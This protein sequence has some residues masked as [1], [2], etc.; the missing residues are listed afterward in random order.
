MKIIVVKQDHSRTQSFRASGRSLAVAAAIISDTVHGDGRR[1]YV[2][3]P[4]IGFGRSS[5]RRRCRKLETNHP[6]TK[7][8]ARHG[9]RKTQSGSWTR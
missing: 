7:A 4:A 2:W 8:G 3:L 5:D 9:S 6:G 1:A